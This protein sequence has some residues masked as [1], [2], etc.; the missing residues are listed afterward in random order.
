M[1]MITIFQFFDSPDTRASSYS[2]TDVA[3]K[4]SFQKSRFFSPWYLT[5]H[6]SIFFLFFFF[7]ISLIV[8]KIKIQYVSYTSKYSESETVT[9]VL[10]CRLI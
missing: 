9:F 4:K 1:V 10:L 7:S 6:L 2:S 5:K 8:S 3:V